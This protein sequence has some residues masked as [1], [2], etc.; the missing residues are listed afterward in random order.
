MVQELARKGPLFERLK[1][2][3]WHKGFA[4]EGT[5][6]VVT[7]GSGGLPG[8]S[9]GVGLL[10]GRARGFFRYDPAPSIAPP[11]AMGRLV[12]AFWPGVLG[13]GILVVSI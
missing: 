1:G 6:S 13:K 7:T 10:S 5:P 8:L 4:F 2:D 12:A 3:A 9:A 11:P